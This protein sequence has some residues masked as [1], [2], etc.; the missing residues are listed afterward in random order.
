MTS[1]HDSV[2]AGGIKCGD[3]VLME[4]RAPRAG[5]IVAVVVNQRI[6]FK[7]ME[8]DSSCEIEGVA[9]GMIR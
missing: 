6:E 7:R 4:K 2:T 9:V 5:E 3:V 8:V 1:E